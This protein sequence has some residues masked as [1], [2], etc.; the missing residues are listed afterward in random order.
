MGIETTFLSM[1]YLNEENKIIMLY[2]R[3]CATTFYTDEVVTTLLFFLL[4][5]LFLT[6]QCRR[7]RFQVLP[8]VTVRFQSIDTAELFQNTHGS[9][10][11]HSKFTHH[12]KVHFQY[13]KCHH[14]GLDGI[15]CWRRIALSPIVSS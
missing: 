9:L 7:E 12:G 1:I 13:R 14:L 4:P 15:T 5:V 11:M 10:L 2:M 6:I 3:C 8:L